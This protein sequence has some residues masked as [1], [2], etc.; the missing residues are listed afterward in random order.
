MLLTNTDILTTLRRLFCL[1]QPVLKRFR[2]EFKDELI[3]VIVSG[4]SDKPEY[5]AVF[6]VGDETFTAVCMYTL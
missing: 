5:T 4:T 6:T 2:R 3:D 1:L